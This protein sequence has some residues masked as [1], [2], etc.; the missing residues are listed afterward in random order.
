[1]PVE[2]NEPK[3]TKEN[4]WLFSGLLKQFINYYPHTDL[5]GTF[6]DAVDT[7]YNSTHSIL[8]LGRNFEQYMNGVYGQPGR[9]EIIET[10]LQS[11]AEKKEVKDSPFLMA[12]LDQILHYLDQVK[13]GESMEE[14]IDRINPAHHQMLRR[15]MEYGAGKD[16]QAAESSSWAE[17]LKE[18]QKLTLELERNWLTQGNTNENIREV[19]NQ[20]KKV[21]GILDDSEKKFTFPKDTLNQAGLEML[22]DVEAADVPLEDKAFFRHL[23]ESRKTLKNLLNH[24][25]SGVKAETINA[26][27]AVVDAI[28][29]VEKSYGSYDPSNLND[30]EIRNKCYRDVLDA[31][32]KLQS[33]DLSGFTLEDMEKIRLARDLGA[34]TED[35]RSAYDD[36]KEKMNQYLDGQLEQRRQRMQEEENELTPERYRKQVTN[37]QEGLKNTSSAIENGQIGVWFG[38]RKYDRVQ[39]RL[40]IFREYWNEIVSDAA[41]ENVRDGNISVTYEQIQ[42][43]RE[44]WAYVM[45]CAEDYL[46][47]KRGRDLNTNGSK[48][49]DAIDRV[50]KY[51]ADISNLLDNMEIKLDQQAMRR[52]MK[53]L[54][55]AEAASTVQP[56]YEGLE[57]EMMDSLIKAE[58]Q[59]NPNMIEGNLEADYGQQLKHLSEEAIRSTEKLLN[60]QSMSPEEKMEAAA[61]VA[62]YAAIKSQIKKIAANKV[63]VADQLK[64]LN[65][66]KKML[67]DPKTQEI[68]VSAAKTTDEVKSIAGRNY[69]QNAEE[70]M[71][72]MQAVQD[73]PTMKKI[74][75]NDTIGS[76]LYQKLVQ[77]TLEIKQNNPVE[78]KEN[79]KEKIN[80]MEQKR[81]EMQ[82]PKKREAKLKELA[83]KHGRGDN[84]KMPGEPD[85]KSE[86]KPEIKAGPGMGPM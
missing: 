77:K 32:K 31:C 24:W 81:A 55:P 45:E 69:L 63:S 75:E 64:D 12:F 59:V 82:D 30:L 42:A 11:F 8:G 18:D 3:Y 37:L 33:E 47:D 2:K 13:A 73:G 38:G 34:R 57:R 27:Q 52:E 50:T 49:F 78:K 20:A 71:A 54:L 43:G 79:L 29:Q 40:N 16:L 84:Q 61:Q 70:W 9:L 58:E 26:M 15:L 53:Q 35:G 60:P 22:T 21:R 76:R 67:T 48:R 65:I 83:N 39:E 25:N 66:V 28:D 68:L 14:A 10:N 5:D 46:K 19:V 74:L 51:D 72:G 80:E 41:P 17:L 7:I 62:V 6:M 85:I 1:M 23:Y 4:M 44:L 56:Y 36:L 86:I